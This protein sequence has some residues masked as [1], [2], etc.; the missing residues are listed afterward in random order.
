MKIDIITIFPKMFEGPFS[1][2][3]VKRAKD[4]ELV[5]I[6]IHDLRKWTNDKRKT[7]DDKPFGGGAG[8]VMMVE[9]IYKAIKQLTTHSPQL[10]TR[11][12]LLSAKGEIY[13]Q[14]RAKQLSKEDHLII[15]AGHYEGI[16]H[17]VYEHI[18]DE[19]ISVGNF[20]MTGG[21][22]PAMA[23]VDSIVRLIPGVLGNEES[24]EGESYSDKDNT[25]KQH[26]VYTR[27]EEFT[28]DEGKVWKVPDVLLS[29]DHKRIEEW[30]GDVVRHGDTW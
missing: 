9:P 12:I 6:N 21:E 17:R 15:I 3:I 29:G 27:P 13:S 16:D 10:T 22:I 18:A 5:E 7:V 1:E 26:P 4:K 23:V 24:L 28:T 2:S 19:I 11:V 14:S 8:M 20:V 25:S 30:K